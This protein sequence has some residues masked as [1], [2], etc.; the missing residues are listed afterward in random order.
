MTNDRNLEYAGI[1]DQDFDD[2][3]ILNTEKLAAINDLHIP[4]PV[5]IFKLKKDFISL[6]LLGT[7][8]LYI[9]RYKLVTRFFSDL[10]FEC[11]FRKKLDFLLDFQ[12]Y[13]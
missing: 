7:Y 6:M 12:N 4:D 2:D 3:F 11:M 13:N 1:A 10:I 8:I 5:I 9:I